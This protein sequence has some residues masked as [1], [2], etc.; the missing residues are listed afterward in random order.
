M[1]RISFKGN[2]IG[3]LKIAEKDAIETSIVHIVDEYRPKGP[4]ENSVLLMT[5]TPDGTVY[6]S[7]IPWVGYFDLDRENLK[8]ADKW[9]IIEPLIV[10]NYE[11]I[12]WKPFK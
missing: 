10:V 3:T 1:S 6:A 12:M 8:E 7:Y 9:N 5:K 4:A 2:K 11:N